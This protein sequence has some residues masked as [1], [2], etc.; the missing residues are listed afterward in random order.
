MVLVRVWKEMVSRGGKE[1]LPGEWLFE[2]QADGESLNC[3]RD[4]ALCRDAAH[5]ATRQHRWWDKG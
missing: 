2:H 4:E 5:L 1:G 3:I